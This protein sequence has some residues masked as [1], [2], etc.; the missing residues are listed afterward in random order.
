MKQK[1]ILNLTLMVTIITGSTFSIL[2]QVQNDKTD[3]KPVVGQKGKDA[4]WV[5]TPQ[6]LVDEMLKVAEVNPN[7]YVIDLGS[8][9]GRIVI[10]AAK[11]GASAMGVEFDPVLVALSIENAIKEGVSEKTKFVEGDFFDTDLSKATVITVFLL[12]EVLLKLQPRFL[13]LKPGT[14]IVSNSFTMGWWIADRHVILENTKDEFKDVF[15]WIVP[16]KVQG[17]WKFLQGNL[18][19]KQDF[20][21]V[22]GFYEIGGNKS[23]IKDSKLRGDT[24]TFSIN[25]EQYTG[26][27]NDSTMSGTFTNNTN[28]IKSDWNAIRISK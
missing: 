16:A 9:D 5:P 22:R 21:V 28:G 8:G 3:S 2:A 11:I 24:L 4:V 13:D 17:M 14:R 25:G 1:V 10:T 6:G 18:T 26:R 12:P 19:L 15:L 20:Q 7:D 23:L 27:V